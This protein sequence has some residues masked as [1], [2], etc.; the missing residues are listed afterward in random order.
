M[1]YATTTTK[2]LVIIAILR[3][4]IASFAVVEMVFG[5]HEPNPGTRCTATVVVVYVT[6]VTVQSLPAGRAR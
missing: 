6:I 3:G 2:H 5:V 1:P 4:S